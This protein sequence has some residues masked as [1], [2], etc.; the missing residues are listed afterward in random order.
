MMRHK[1]FLGMVICGALLLLTVCGCVSN[2]SVGSKPAFE[3]GSIVEGG[4]AVEVLAPAA[5]T[6]SPAA[7]GVIAI[8][9]GH[10]VSGNFSQEP[11]GPGAS[12]T[13]ARVTSGTSGTSTG[14]E[15]NAVNLAVALKLQASLEARGITVVMVRTTANVDISNSERAA[16]A[17]EA[18]AALFIRLHCDGV[19]NSSTNGFMTLIPSENK[20]TGS[21]VAQSARAADIM[22]PMIISTIGAND[23]GIKERSDLSGFNWCTVP[24]ILFEMGCMSN[25]DED[26]RLGSSSYQQTM[27]DAI[28]EA[29]V[30]YLNA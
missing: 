23:R 11:I 19:D 8:D 27:A 18:N 12:E 10:Q 29:T 28:A 26:E 30:A 7:L 4:K 1:A 16:I 2:K 24:T 5:E 9:A 14:N 13:K 21:I 15:E 25:P 22:H 17:N 3:V 6:T 20:W